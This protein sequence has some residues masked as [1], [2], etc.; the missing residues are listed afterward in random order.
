MNNRLKRLL[1]IALLLALFIW[2]A[3]FTYLFAV[4]YGEEL[5]DYLKANFYYPSYLSN[6]NSYW[7]D[8]EFIQKKTYMLFWYLNG[9]LVLFCYLFFV[10]SNPQYLDEL[11]KYSLKSLIFLSLSCACF[12]VIMNAD[13]MYEKSSVQM[14]QKV[15]F[16][17]KN[18]ILFY[19]LF[20]QQWAVVLV[21]C[22]GGGIFFIREMLTRICWRKIS[23]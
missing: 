17:L 16:L 19:S 14:G 23:G 11:K 22:L 12:F 10:I 18:D 13:F 3:L 7:L 5:S 6:L 21:L 1:H 9:Y 2:P 8:D 20:A 15:D 4:P